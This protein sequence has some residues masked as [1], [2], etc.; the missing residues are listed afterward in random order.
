LSTTLLRTVTFGDLLNYPKNI[1]DLF[2]D[3]A[4]DI[5]KELKITC[6]FQYLRVLKMITS[7]ETK[8]LMAR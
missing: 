4:V 6:R 2:V 3:G 5:G 8:L 1:S 7:N